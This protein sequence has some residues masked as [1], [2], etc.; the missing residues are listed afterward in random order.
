[1]YRY[2]LFSLAGLVSQV[3]CSKARANKVL[4]GKIQRTVCRD[5]KM[6]VLGQSE[7]LSISISTWL[8]Y[9]V[10]KLLLKIPN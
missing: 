1:M 7:I 8:I 9:R 5:N 3:L 6:R 10:Q 2:E 4:F